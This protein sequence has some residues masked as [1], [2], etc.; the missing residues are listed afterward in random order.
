[1]KKTLS[2]LTKLARF[3]EF[4]YLIVIT[5]LLG[6]ATAQGAFDLR[7]VIAL[8]A[9]W[10][11][12]S[13]AYMVNDIEDAPDDAFSMKNYQRNPISIGLISPKTARTAAII[14]GLLA[15]GCYALLGL[16][17]F[18]LGLLCLLLG[19]MYSVK[20]IRLKTIAFI[21]LISRG[22]ILAGLPFLCGYFAFTSVLY[23]TWIWPFLFVMCLTVFYDHR[24]EMKTDE[25]EEGSRLRR[26]TALFGER[27]ATMVTVFLILVASSGIISFF[28]INLVPAWVMIV[29]SA[30]VLLFF[31]P[32][33]IKTRKNETSELMPGFLINTL[34]RSAAIGLMLQFVIPWMVQFFQSGWF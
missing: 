1:M 29:I 20:T 33:Y 11:A 14:V 15:A 26:T 2:G 31:V 5:T 8:F 9:N 12:A 32:T 34:G 21:D 6:I 10:L 19:I 24:V 7:L 25:G 13:F 18:I 16:W 22:L 17:S 27:S 30:L 23:R 4:G 28:L 3:D